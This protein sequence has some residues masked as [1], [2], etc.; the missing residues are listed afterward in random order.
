MYEATGEK[1]VELER[2]QSMDC[3]YDCFHV[4]TVFQAL[5]TTRSSNGFGPNPITY[6]E[7]IAY[8]QCGGI[9]LDSEEIDILKQIDVIYMDKMNAF[10][11][12]K[13]SK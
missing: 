8:M 11:S 7:I 3:P 13:M 9:W 10:L 1:P 12:K 6:Q 5:C 2:L 4:W